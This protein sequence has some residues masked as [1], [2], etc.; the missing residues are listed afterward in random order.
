M[1]KKYMR[2]IQKLPFYA[3]IV[4]YG[5][6][7]THLK[8]SLRQENIFGANAPI[9]HPPPPPPPRWRC[10]CLCALWH[11]IYMQVLLEKP[12]KCVL[13]SPPT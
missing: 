12:V 2:S 5:L 7:L 10:H 8:L 3:E 11:Y 1:F 6:I 13:P 4:K 9:L